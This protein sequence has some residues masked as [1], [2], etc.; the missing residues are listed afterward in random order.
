MGF[1]GDDFLNCVIQLRTSLSPDKTLKTILSI[2]K[3]MG[4]VRNK[5]GDYVSRP[6]DIDMLFFDDECKKQ[7]N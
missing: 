2:E 1:D 5:T 3:K 6:I 4:R 7:K